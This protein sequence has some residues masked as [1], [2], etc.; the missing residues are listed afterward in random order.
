MAGSLLF[1][2]AF[3]GLLFFLASGNLLYFKLFTDLLAE[4]RQFQALGKVGILPGE[5][6]RVVSAQT[7][8]LF[9]MPLLLAVLNAFMMVGLTARMNTLSLWQPMAAVYVALF[10]GYRLVTRQTYA[11][12]LLRQPWAERKDRPCLF[13]RRSS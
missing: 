3:V 5:V 4:Q 8:V 10:L 7:L 13:C 9:L 11:A 2:G 1:V 6:R 12:A